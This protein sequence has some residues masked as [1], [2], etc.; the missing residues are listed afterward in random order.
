MPTERTFTCTN[1]GTVDS[2][3][4]EFPGGICLECYRPE[5]ERLHR[6]MTAE[7]LAEMWGGGRRAVASAWLEGFDFEGEES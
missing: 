3:L 5:G 4:A 1:C 6:T 2:Y 7:K